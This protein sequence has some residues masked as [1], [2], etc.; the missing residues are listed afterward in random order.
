M[1]YKQLFHSEFD[2]ECNINWGFEKII[3]LYE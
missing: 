3:E 2:K 1:F